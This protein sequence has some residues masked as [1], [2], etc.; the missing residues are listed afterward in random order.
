ME[1]DTCTQVSTQNTWLKGDGSFRDRTPS[2]LA[3]R[4]DLNL[5]PILPALRAGRVPVIALALPTWELPVPGRTLP[6]PALLLV[7]LPAPL[8]ALLSLPG[9]PRQP[10]QLRNQLLDGEDGLHHRVH[11]LAKLPVELLPDRRILSPCRRLT[12]LPPGASVTSR[13]TPPL[14]GHG[15]SL[16]VAIVDGKHAAVP[17]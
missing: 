16:Q 3:L 15:G 13:I 4:L 11:I 9:L 10:A 12:S 7:L 14:S 6:L 2:R 5:G 17:E 1:R 8:V